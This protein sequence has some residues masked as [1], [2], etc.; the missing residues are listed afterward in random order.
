MYIRHAVP[1][2]GALGTDNAGGG[3]G[4]SRVRGHGTWACLCGWVGAEEGRVSDRVHEG[5][6]ASVKYAP[7]DPSARPPARPPR[8][9]ARPPAQRPP[10]RLRGAARRARGGEGGVLTRAWW[11][12]IVGRCAST[13]KG[14]HWPLPEVR[15]SRRARQGSGRRGSRRRQARW[16]MQGEG[17]CTQPRRG[18]VV[19][20]VD[21][22]K[23]NPIADKTSPYKKQKTRSGG[24]RANSLAGREQNKNR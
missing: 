9:P 17:H 5:T 20:C 2:P 10:A 22:I 16:P 19:M 4:T 23:D 21:S 24:W 14:V 13:G 11:W 7:P 6:H 3:H 8:T 1:A 15:G 18:H 12:C